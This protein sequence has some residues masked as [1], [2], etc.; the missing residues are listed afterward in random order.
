MKRIA[1]AALLGVAEIGCALE[2]GALGA[3]PGDGSASDDVASAA[4]RLEGMNALSLN[5]L[6]LN[7]LSLN[8]LSLN[9]LS[10]SA[11]DPSALASI[12]SSGPSGELARQFVRYAAG[13]SLDS[14][15]SFELSW[16]DALG[17]HSETV[18]GSLGLATS[19]GTGP[20]SSSEEQWVSACLL[21][22]VNW[23]A[24][25]VMISLRGPHHALAQPDLN[26]ATTYDVLE[27]AFWGNIFAATPTAFSCNV[28]SNIATSRARKR[29]CA[30]GHIEPPNSVQQCGI[31]DIAGECHT[32]CD[33]PEAGE[34]YY[35]ACNVPG[36]AAG[37]VITVWLH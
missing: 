34:S 20:L 8:A 37:P 28:G 1:V 14:S 2:S 13:C 3:G 11:L 32:R 12:Q 18:W 15:Q 5:A 16:T 24:T 27:G 29:D 10:L 30:A 9:A 7:A 22:R 19:W 17:P 23:Y 21:A 31:I 35:P 36:G 4:S 6:S 25:T 33:P 26:E